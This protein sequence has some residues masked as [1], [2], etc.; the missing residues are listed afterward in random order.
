MAT[1]IRVPSLGE[2]VS[3]A[4]VGKWQKKPGDAV[5]AGETLVELETDKVTLEVPAPATGTVSEIT[6]AEGETVGPNGLLG[7]IAEGA[8]AKA[9]APKAEPAKAE[10]AK[11]AA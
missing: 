2:S 9:E 11:A 4:T 1:E 7:M 6:A 10:P 3:E 5:A 8:A